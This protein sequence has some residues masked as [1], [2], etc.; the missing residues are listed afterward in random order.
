MA[1]AFPSKMGL[2]TIMLFFLFREMLGL[3]NIL[4]KKKKKKKKK[5]LARCGIT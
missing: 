2:G 1:L 4:Q 3:Q 5:P